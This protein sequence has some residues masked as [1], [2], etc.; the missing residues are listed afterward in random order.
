[1][2]KSIE[3]NKVFLYRSGANRKALLTVL[4]GSFIDRRAAQEA[5]DALPAELQ[6]NRPFLRTVRGIRA[7]IL[8]TQSS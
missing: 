4:Y 6:V 8:R 1:L 5:L 3:I 7:E 2:A